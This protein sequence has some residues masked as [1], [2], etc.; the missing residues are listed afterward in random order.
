LIAFYPQ[1]VCWFHYFNLGVLVSC[2]RDEFFFETAYNLNAK[3]KKP[4]GLKSAHGLERFTIYYLHFSALQADRSD[5][6]NT[7]NNNGKSRLKICSAMVD[8]FKLASG[9]RLS[10]CPSRVNK[11]YIDN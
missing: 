4:W 8:P 11:K 1:I 5:K 9:H 2:F 10:E 3:T 6:N 7:G